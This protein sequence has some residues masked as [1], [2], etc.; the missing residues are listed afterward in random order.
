MNARDVLNR[1][2]TTALLFQLRNTKQFLHC[3]SSSKVIGSASV[4]LT[5]MPRNK[6]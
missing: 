3:G 5:R 4:T 1:R 2:C 6:C